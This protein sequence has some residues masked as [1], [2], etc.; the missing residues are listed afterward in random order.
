MNELLQLAD[1]ARRNDPTA[2]G[3]LRRALESRMGPIIRRA[4][5]RGVGD[6]ALNRRILVEA[7]REGDRPDR[8][9]PHE[10]EERVVRRL[11]DSVLARLRPF[12]N[13]RAPVRDTIVA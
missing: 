11:C 9:S 8:L 7:D 13:G 6:T 12:G 5:R 1:R 3:D 2:A 4:M 10:C